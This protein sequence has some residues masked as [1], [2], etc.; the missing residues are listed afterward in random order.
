[1]ATEVKV[2]MAG[3]IIRSIPLEEIKAPPLW[4][5]R[6]AQVRRLRVVAYIVPGHGFIR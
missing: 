3:A 1:M 6:T 4:I 2:A 5:I